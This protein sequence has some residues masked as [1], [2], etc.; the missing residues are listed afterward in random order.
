MTS[1]MYDP[2]KTSYQYRASLPPYRVLTQASLKQMSS[3]KNFGI[4]IFMV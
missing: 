2:E 3:Y 4:A 1:V